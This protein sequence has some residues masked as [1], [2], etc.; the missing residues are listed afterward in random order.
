MQT[1]MQTAVW[2]ASDHLPALFPG[3]EVFLVG[4]GGAGMSGLARALKELG[5]APQGSDRQASSATRSLVAEGIPVHIGHRAENI[6]DQ[7]KLLVHTPAVGPDNIEFQAAVASGIPIT[8]RFAILGALMD[9][10]EAIAVAGTHG[11]TTTSGLLA[12]CLDAGERT[13]GFF[14]G[15]QLPYFGTNAR[16][17]NGPLVIEAD[18]Y[19]RS[20]LNGHPRV[21]IITNLEHDHPDIYPSLESLLSAFRSFAERVQDLLIV[22]AAW[23][24]AIEAL[25]GLDTRRESGQLSIEYYWVEGDPAPAGVSISAEDASHRTT[26]EADAPIESSALP[27]GGDIRWQAINIQNDQQGQSFEVLRDGSS[28][29]RFELALAGRHNVGNALAVIACAHAMDLSFEALKSVFRSYRGAGRRFQE[30]ATIE[31]IKLIDDYAHHPT[32]IA[33][34]IQAARSRMLAPDSDDP[35]GSVQTSGR[36]PHPSG[37]ILCVIEPHTFSRVQLLNED[38]STAIGLAD[39]T[40]VTPIYAA[41]EEAPD[42]VDLLAFVDQV[43]NAERSESL[44]SAAQAIADAAR[45]GDTL[46]FMG[47]GNIQQSSRHCAEILRAGLRKELVRAAEEGGYGGE[48]LADELLSKH[49]SMRVGGPATLAVR[50]KQLDDLKAWW[51]LAHQ[52]HCPVRVIGRGSNIVVSDAGVDGL[53]ILN[54]CEAWEVEAGSAINM[55]SAASSTLQGISTSEADEDDSVSVICE[56]GVTLAALGSS[57]ARQGYCGIE[58]GVGIPGSVGAGV[59]TNAGAHGWEM[60]DSVLDVEILGHDGESK[61]VAASDLDFRYRGSALKGDFDRLVLRA[62]LKLKVDTRENIQSRIDRFQSHRRE[63]QP[64]EPS[65]GSVFKNPA[66]DY[67]GRLLESLGKKGYSIGDAYVS[68]IHANFIINRDSARSEDVIALIQELRSLVAERFGTDLE[69]EIEI[70]ERSLSNRTFRPL[71]TSHHV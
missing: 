13:P 50:V 7:C 65:V 66:E 44:E 46:L 14:I 28:L 45:P 64:R 57:L 32:E 62:R 40:W 48:I 42:S 23:P 41:R 71:R 25:D 4:I 24:L 56:S 27:E 16:L 68:D 69:T 63:T 60:A 22:N 43:D 9:A 67:A 2:P 55:E 15:A 20:F 61:W 47:A 11:K 30:L 10:R 1:L 49:T 8:K 52:L 12:A 36:P 21:G 59:V 26:I 19:D 38:F 70:V 33:A 6:S 17:G 3:D 18:E 35:T 53:I 54:R 39:R 37:R 51:L 31:G 34:T 5:L 29:G 58:Y